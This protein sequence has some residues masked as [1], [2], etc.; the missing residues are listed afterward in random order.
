MKRIVQSWVMLITMGI[1][2]GLGWALEVTSGVYSLTPRGTPV[3][4]GVLGNPDI[5]GVS[6]RLPWEVVEPIEGQYDFSYFVTEMNRIRA[7]GKKIILRIAS[8]GVSTPRWVFEAG[9]AT[10]TYVDPT[11]TSPTY[12]QLIT[13]PV[14]WDPIYLAKKKAMIAAMGE[15]L[16]PQ[17]QEVMLIAASCVQTTSDDWVMPMTADDIAQWQAIGYTTAKVVQACVEIVDATMAAFPSQN[18]LMALGR[19]TNQLDPNA[20]Y[21]A[22]VVSDYA[23]ANYPGR[24]YAQKNSLSAVTPDPTSTRTLF[25]WQLLADYWPYIGAQMLWYVSGDTTCRMNGKVQPCDA[26]TVLTRAVE[27]GAAYGTKYQ[28]IYQKDILDPALRA[29]MAYAASLLR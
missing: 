10:F 3:A 29:V 14:F 7:A 22:R 21:V 18:V 25:S 16:R 24:F 11:P 23:R 5:A 8:G 27:I 28:E 12:G 26:A 13:I 19:G 4:D 1:L 9:A 6:L 15:S 17:S 2:A 20:D